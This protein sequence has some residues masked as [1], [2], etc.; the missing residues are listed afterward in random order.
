MIIVQALMADEMYCMTPFSSFFLVP[1]VPDTQ[2]SHKASVV[3]ARLSHVV[4][5]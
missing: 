1:L 3:Q 5:C 4:I 2:V